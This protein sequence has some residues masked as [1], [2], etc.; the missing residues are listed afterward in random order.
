[1]PIWP[2]HNTKEV[3]PNVIKRKRTFISKRHIRFDHYNPLSRLQASTSCHRLYNNLIQL[4]LNLEVLDSSVFELKCNKKKKKQIISTKILTNFHIKFIFDREVIN[5]K[6][7]M[8]WAFER[9]FLG[10]TPSLKL[11]LCLIYTAK[12]LRYYFLLK[13]VVAK[14]TRKTPNVHLQFQ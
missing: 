3:K 1:M 6:N 14:Q 13:F 11:K 10:E 5:W 7:C 4:P 2:Y 12:G 8:P 9:Y